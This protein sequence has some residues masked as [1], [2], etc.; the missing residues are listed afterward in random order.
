MSATGEVS[1]VWRIFVTQRQEAELGEIIDA[2]RLRPEQTKSFIQA[3]FRDGTVATNGTAITQILPPVSRFAK[4]NNLGAKKQ[5][6]ATKLNAYFE[7]F[8]GVA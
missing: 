5:R 2:E 3:A 1:D 6:V 4:D 8:F 7:R